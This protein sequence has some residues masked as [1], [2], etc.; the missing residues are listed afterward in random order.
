MTTIIRLNNGILLTPSPLAY[1]G[2]LIASNMTVA[3]WPVP[4]AIPFL[5]LKSAGFCVI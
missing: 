1:I 5:V 3:R 2:V 4:L